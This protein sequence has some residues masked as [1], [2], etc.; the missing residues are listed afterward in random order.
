MGGVTDEGLWEMMIE[1]CSDE[2]F[3][4]AHRSV[5]EDQPPNHLHVPS[6]VYQLLDNPPVFVMFTGHKIAKPC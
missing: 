5:S 3:N 1:G 2:M 4:Y 6:L